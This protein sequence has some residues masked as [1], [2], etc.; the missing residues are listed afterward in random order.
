MYFWARTA[1]APKSK[2]QAEFVVYLG[3][4]EEP[5][6][7]IFSEEFSPTDEWKAYTLSGVAKSNFSGGKLKAEY[8]IGK[9]I[10]TVEFGGMYVSNLGPIAE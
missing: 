8:Q 5:H 4:N 3:R 7:N 10:Q 1:K 6:D 9:Q 2:E